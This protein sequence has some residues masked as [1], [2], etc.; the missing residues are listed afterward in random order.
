MD[1]QNM[2]VRGK[3]RGVPDDYKGKTIGESAY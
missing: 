1:A 3:M 2:Y